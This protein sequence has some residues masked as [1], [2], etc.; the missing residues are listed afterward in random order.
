MGEQCE[1]GYYIVAMRAELKRMLQNQCYI[2]PAQ[3]L[4]PARCI[5]ALALLSMGKEDYLDEIT[6][7]AVDTPSETH[8]VREYIDQYVKDCKKR[9]LVWS[10]PLP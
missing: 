5:E 8:K 2:P 6:D 10:P 7:L 1:L 3:G 4:N 9:Q